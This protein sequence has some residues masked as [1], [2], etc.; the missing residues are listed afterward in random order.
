[1][2][3]KKCCAELSCREITDELKMRTR[4]F[5]EKDY[6]MK[7]LFPAIGIKDQEM[8]SGIQR[9]HI[10]QVIQCTTEGVVSRKKR[11]RLIADYRIE[12]GIFSRSC[13]Q[14]TR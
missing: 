4:V 9:Q 14:S 3:K 6:I 8:L 10:E 13:H 5:T 2:K 7:Q 11:L 12:R 1:M